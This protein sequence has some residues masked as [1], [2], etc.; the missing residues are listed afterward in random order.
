MTAEESSTKCR[1][2]KTKS[3]SGRTK[4]ELVFTDSDLVNPQN[5]A[6]NREIKHLA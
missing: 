6:K 4:S 1:I 2:E 5:R 3:E